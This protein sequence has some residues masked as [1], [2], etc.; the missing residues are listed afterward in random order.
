MIA[1]FN[2]AIVRITWHI[3]VAPVNGHIIRQALYGLRIERVKGHRQLCDESAGRC[4]GDGSV[5]TNR[6][7]FARASHL[8]PVIEK[9]GGNGQTEFAKGKDVLII[10]ELVDG[11]QVNI[12]FTPQRS[13]D[14]L[15]DIAL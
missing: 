13:Y 5:F 3:G 12:A 2:P 11:S 8:V 4:I 6:K 7:E 15:P 10:V 1:S 14:A 9:H